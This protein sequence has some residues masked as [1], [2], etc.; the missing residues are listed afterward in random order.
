MNFSESFFLNTILL[1]TTILIL[2]I[3][4]CTCTSLNTITP[5]QPLKDGD[6]LV[7]TRNTFALGF[8]SPSNSNNRYIGIWYNKV[9]QQTVVWVANR[10]NPLIND[11]SGVL[12]VNGQGGLILHGRNRNSPLWSANVSVHNT[13]T[14]MAKL[15]NVGNLVLLDQNNT[16]QNLI[17]Q[18]FDH[19]TDTM[20]PFMK[21]GLNRVSG[22]DWVLTSWK[23]KDDPGTGNYTCLI[24]PNGYPQ[25]FLNLGRVPKWRGGPWTGLRWS[26]VPEMAPPKFILN[27]SFVN[28][29][30]QVIITYGILNDSI[31]SRMMVDESGT[32]HRSTWQDG[33][34]QW[35]EFWSAP[36][37]WCDNY[38]RCGP[39]GYCDPSDASK[40]ECTCLPGFQPG[41]PRNWELRD[42]SGGC[43]RKRDAHVCGNGE[44][45]VKIAHAKLPD[46]S[47]ARVEMG[48]SLRA[49]EQV[50]LKDCNCTA[51]TSANESRDGDG[52]L[53]WHGDL[54]DMRT[55][56]GAG[57][58]L[59]VR[60]DAITLDYNQLFSYTR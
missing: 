7:S 20:L 55:Y 47:V 18:S 14:S 21:L 25:F 28:D 8:F 39:N 33:A 30:D 31:F 5:D 6:V 48:L 59:Y 23:S 26:G 27:V 38:G 11:T 40:F 51:Y 35:V 36:S 53:T 56:S 41:S 54:V 15:L 42:A 9:P 57:Q 60:V 49:C 2:A 50:C 3:P 17:W 29:P 12:T 10:D 4:C 19:P 16:A 13:N 22:L 58:D 32:V 37:E 45:F 24:D 46:T 43:V 1:I 44:G 52:C 34:R